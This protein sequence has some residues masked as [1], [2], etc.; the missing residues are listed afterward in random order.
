MVDWNRLGHILTIVSIVSIA[1]LILCMLILSLAYVGAG[2]ILLSI[3][4]SVYYAY[5]F[6]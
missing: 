6:F 1:G 2:Y 4:E 3:L 5:I